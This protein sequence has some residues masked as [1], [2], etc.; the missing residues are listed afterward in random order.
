MAPCRKEIELPES[1][2]KVIFSVFGNVI[3]QA[4]ISIESPVNGEKTKGET[5]LAKEHIPEMQP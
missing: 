5:T 2:A 3:T 4:Y 1:I